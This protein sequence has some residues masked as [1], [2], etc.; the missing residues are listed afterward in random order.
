M[1]TVI[2]RALRETESQPGLFDDEPSRSFGEPPEAK[3]AAR[4]KG[5]EANG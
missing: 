5:G 3:I 1:N 2:N 4:G